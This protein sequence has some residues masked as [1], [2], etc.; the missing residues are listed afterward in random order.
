MKKLTEKEIIEILEKG[1]ISEQPENVKEQVYFY[2]F[3][4]KFVKSKNK[5]A[6]NEYTT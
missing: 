6:L 4:K 5:G 3:G 1:S 2:A